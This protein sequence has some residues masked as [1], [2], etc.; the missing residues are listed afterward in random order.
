MAG[1]RNGILLL[2]GVASVGAGALHLFAAGLHT[3]HATLARLM[4]VLAAAQ[5]AVGFVAAMSA[6]KAVPLTVIGVNLVAVAIWGYTRFAGLPW[7]DGLDV[8]EAPQFLDSTCAALGVLTIAAATVALVRP[9]ATL[10]P[11]STGIAA[12]TAGVLAVA[13]MLGGAGHVHSHDGG[14]DHSHAAG[15]DHADHHGTGDAWPRPWDPAT[16]INVSG[17]P[18]VTAEQEQR[19]TALIRTTLDRPPSPTSIPL[20]HWASNPSAMRPPGTSTISISPTF[21]TIGSSTPPTPSHW[22]T[23]STARIERWS[24]RCI[25][26]RAKRSTTPN[27]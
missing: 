5:C 18:G 27:W 26:P 25:S 22:S 1:G 2:G 4:V 13:A 24:R 8:A 14:G 3:E 17:V 15:G 20:A 16:P 21:V 23:G 10:P 9:E 19:A 11:V 6:R 12:G 7:P